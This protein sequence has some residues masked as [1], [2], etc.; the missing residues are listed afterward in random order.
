MLGTNALISRPNAGCT[1]QASQPIHFQLCNSFDR[2]RMPV[3][4]ADF[5]YLPFNSIF[6]G[7]L[8]AIA[9]AY[10]HGLPAAYPVITELFSFQFVK[11]EAVSPEITCLS[12]LFPHIHLTLVGLESY[13]ILKSC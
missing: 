3:P 1:D 12:V 9:P 5:S 10:I 8:L 6:S 7:N 13:G 2:F 4:L 11:R